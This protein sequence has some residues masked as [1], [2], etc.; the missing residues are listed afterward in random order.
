M[1]HPETDARFSEGIRLF[2]QAN[3]FEA[4]EVWEEE[5]KKAAGVEKLFYQGLIQAAAALLHVQRGNYAGAISVFLKSR[6]KLDQFPALWMGIELGGFRSELASYFA[7]LR[8]SFDARHGNY[9]PAR[10]E[11]TASAAQ[12]P[13]IRWARYV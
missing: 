9:Q 6:S 12:P 5:W 7:G 2:N 1:T 11:Q 4:H 8:T 3:F 13:T 10:D